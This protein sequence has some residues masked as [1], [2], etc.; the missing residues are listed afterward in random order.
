MSPGKKNGTPLFA[1]G[2]SW[3]PPQEDFLGHVWAQSHPDTLGKGP[4]CVFS[5]PGVPHMVPCLQVGVHLG[6]A[7]FEKKT[8]RVHF[9]LDN[10]LKGQLTNSWEMQGGIFFCGDYTK[11]G[12]EWHP[13]CPIIHLGCPNAGGCYVL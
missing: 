6:Q 5:P 9:T 4:E 11:K 3:S 7:I 1:V 2:S 12:S 8:T 10:L 13:G